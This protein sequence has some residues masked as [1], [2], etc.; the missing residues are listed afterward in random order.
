MNAYKIKFMLDVQMPIAAIHTSILLFFK[1]LY[2]LEIIF[3]WFI[4]SDLKGY[5]LRKRSTID[6]NYGRMSKLVMVLKGVK[7]L[8]KKWFLPG[9][10][11]FVK[12]WK[13]GMFSFT[14]RLRSSIWSLWVCVTYSG[15]LE[16]SCSMCTVSVHATKPSLTLPREES[17][18]IYARLE[19]PES[20]K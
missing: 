4:C 5:I 7:I 8:F 14:N 10:V 12:V 1:L 11:A 20:G 6:E 2:I 9:E 13:I 15:A 3:S 17:S 19:L 16:T 18:R